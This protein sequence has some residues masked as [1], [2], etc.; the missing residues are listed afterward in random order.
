MTPMLKFSPDG[1]FAVLCVSIQE[2]R[3]IRTLIGMVKGSDEP[4][5]PLYRLLYDKGVDRFGYVFDEHNCI[6]I[7]YGT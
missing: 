4:A 6:V 3:I 7:D 5:D 2:L 1:E